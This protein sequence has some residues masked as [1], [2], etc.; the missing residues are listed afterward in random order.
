M[1]AKTST[2]RRFMTALKRHWQSALPGV[3]PVAEKVG[4]LSRGLTF[5]AG[6]IAQFEQ[7][8]YLEF[9]NGRY[10]PG[11]F[12]INV[13]V[14][15]KG[16][17]PTASMVRDKPGEKRANGGRRIGD[18][19]G[20]QRTDKWWHL[21]EISIDDTRAN[22]RR[23]HWSATSYANEDEVIAAAVAD[24]TQDVEVALKALGASSVSAAS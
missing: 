9:Q 15:D 22:L 20:D 10:E 4:Y 23:G 17:E 2:F 7:Q 14:A 3:R 5:D 24:V 19:V 21:C 11:H 12:T 1:P 8:V 16:R 13:I 18:F 6:E